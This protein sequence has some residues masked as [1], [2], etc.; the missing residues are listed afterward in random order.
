MRLGKTVILLLLLATVA[1]GQGTATIEGHVYDEDLNGLTG[2]LVRVQTMDGSQTQVVATDEN[3]RYV[4]T[5]HPGGT[6]R[7]TFLA[8]G[9][10]AVE[11]EVAF[12][13]G[14]RTTVNVRL[15]L[16]D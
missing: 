5:S 15:P 7:M 6:H 16:Q 1:L 12:Q 11:L 14:G 2:A 3:G 9:H 4:I 13:L 8:P 10:E